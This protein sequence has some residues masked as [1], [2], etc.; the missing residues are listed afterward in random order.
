[1]TDAHWCVRWRD[2]RQ[3]ASRRSGGLG[4]AR[5]ASEPHEGARARECHEGSRR[6]HAPTDVEQRETPTRRHGDERGHCCEHAHGGVTRRP[7]PREPA[8]DPRTERRGEDGRH[9]E[10]E[11][12]H[13]L[14]LSLRE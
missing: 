6:A 13:R 3:S 12:L 8:E 2:A 11:A 14:R 5:S 7:P 9:E 1:M 10:R 4:R